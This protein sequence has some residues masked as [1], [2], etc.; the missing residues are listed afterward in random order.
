MSIA[1]RSVGHDCTSLIGN[2]GPRNVSEGFGAVYVRL[3]AVYLSANRFP[4][5]LFC[6]LHHF[7]R[8]WCQTYY[9]VALTSWANSN[10]CCLDNM[11]NNFLK[12]VT[13]NEGS[14]T[15]YI[16]TTAEILN[17]AYVKNR[18]AFKRSLQL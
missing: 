7:R 3:N 6:L 2:I 12:N 17:F 18:R 11:L 8:K 16:E 14:K 4:R 15:A 13:E 10:F 5:L 1:K 9:F